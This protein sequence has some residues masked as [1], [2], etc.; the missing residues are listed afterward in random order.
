MMLMRHLGVSYRAA[1]RV[2]HKLMVVMA[3]REEGK[4]LNGFIELD[5]AYLGGERSG[6]VG[7]GAA[8]KLPFVAAVQTSAEGHPEQAKFQVVDGF[9]SRTI[10]RWAKKALSPDCIVISDGLACFRAVQKAG[11]IHAPLVCGG[12]KSSVEEPELYWVN[13]LLGNLKSILRGTFHAFHFKYAQ[14]YLSEFQYRFNR[15]FDLKAMLPRLAYVA[16]RTPPIPEW[17][18]MRLRYEHN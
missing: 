15:R 18:L 7:R 4:S 6:Q 8:H 17:L 9:R 13:T 11:C 12:G 10:E 3:E 2:K 14:L 5:D 1:L 16:V